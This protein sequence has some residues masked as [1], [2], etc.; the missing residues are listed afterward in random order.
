MAQGFTI[1][2]NQPVSLYKI[3]EQDTTGWN[4]I[5]Q[6]LTKEDCKVQYNLQISQGTSPERL[7]I[8]K[9]Q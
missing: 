2:S 5:T 6:P 1:K 9:V 3:Q 7:K 4:D 8:V